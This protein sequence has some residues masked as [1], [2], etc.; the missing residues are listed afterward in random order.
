M[1]KKVMVYG[2]S[3]T[4]GWIGVEQAYPSD[5]YDDEQRWAGVMEKALGDDYQVSVD[6]LTV[7]STNLDDAMDWNN[8]TADM[9]NGARLLPCAIAREMPLDL[10][11]IALGTNDLKAETARSASDIANALVE[12]AAIAANCANGVAYNYPAPKVI[13]VAPAPVGEMPH[14][15]FA[16]MFEGAQQKSLELGGEL[17]KQAAAAGVAMFDAGSATGQTAGVDGL[18]FSEEQHQLLGTAMAEQVKKV[19]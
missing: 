19:I 15:D 11:I 9:F 10:V 7:R 5:R 4:W 8:I 18:H 12:L 6:G 14:P 17:T 1:T 2:D 13:L 16:G 3:N